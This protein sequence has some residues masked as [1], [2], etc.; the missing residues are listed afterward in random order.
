MYPS[1]GSSVLKQWPTSNFIA[2]GQW[3]RDTYG[4]KI[5]IVGGPGEDSVCREV[6]E[7]IG[8]GA[9]IACGWLGLRVTAAVFK[10]STLFIGNDTGPTHMAAAM[11][12]PVFAIF[13]SS[14]HHRFAPKGDNCT[15]IWKAF[16]CSACVASGHVDRCSK[17]IY[18]GVPCLEAITPEDL[19]RAVKAILEK[20][21]K[22]NTRY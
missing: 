9:S 1:G 5:L 19:K 21:P 12:V 14:C 11:E 3:I 22:S 4:T 7:G 15:L 8:K 10:K 2:L 13:G 16:K 20:Q 17:C 6:S 18:H